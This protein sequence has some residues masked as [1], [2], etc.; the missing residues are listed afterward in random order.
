MKILYASDT[1]VHP[2]HFSRLLHAGE[3]LLPDAIIVGGD[4]NPNWR[5]DIGAS[6]EPHRTWI[7]ERLL[8]RLRAFR[9]ARPA[10]P[11]LLDLGNDDI[12]AP[13]NLLEDLDGRD[14]HLLHGRVVRIGPQVAVAGYMTVNPTP[15]AIKDWEKPDCRDRPG[16]TDPGVARSG[17]VTRSGFPES[18]ELALSSGTMEEDLES[19]SDSMRDP[20][21]EGCGFVFV[22]HAPPRDSLLD[23]TGHR[24]HVGSLAVR[25]FLEK[26]SMDGR[27]LVS[28]HGHIH[29]SPWE[30]GS[31]RDTVGNVPC[32]NI[33][34]KRQGLRAL[35]FETETPV[36]SARLVTVESSGELTVM[37]EGVWL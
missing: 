27:V 4:V 13:R 14:L 28:L 19:L 33:G 20:G 10:I 35:L 2:A 25:R 34:Q 37:E 6:I 23:L 5:G 12:A 18:F 26:W 29:E 16:L 15:F 9:E 1:H 24:V 8:P 30:S 31:V 17:S 11:V 3:E 32:F 22:C 7:R 21:F 36:A